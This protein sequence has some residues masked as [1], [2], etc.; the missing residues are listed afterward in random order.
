LRSGAFSPKDAVVTAQM[1][2]FEALLAF[3]FVFTALRQ[4][5]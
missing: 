2:V 4:G 3:R 1:L 5:V